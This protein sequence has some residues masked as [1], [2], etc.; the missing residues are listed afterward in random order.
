MSL[1]AAPLA[2]ETDQP[3]TP[4]SGAPRSSIL[5]RRKDDDERTLPL[6]T[7][8]EEVPQQ[9]IAMLVMARDSL[10][11]LVG[12]VFEC[13]VEIVA[14]ILRLIQGVAGRE[15]AEQVDA[16][17][18]GGLGAVLA[19]PAGPL[20]SAPPPSALEPAP[21]EAEP[22]GA[23]SRARAP[24]SDGVDARLRDGIEAIFSAHAQSDEE[25]A[26][27]SP[28]LVEMATIGAQFLLS[29]E[30]QYPGAIDAL[31]GYGAAGLGAGEAAAP[32]GGSAPAEEAPA[33][34][35]GVLL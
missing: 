27:I 5:P 14:S 35:R 12:A 1:T 10:F 16:W 23:P 24:V 13:A 4:A 9:T 2:S 28:S 20:Q 8:D 6:P 33:E 34:Q 22:A 30:R 18:A 29:V 7:D 31:Q 15:V 25:R 3:R 17:A 32:G 21:V 19:G 26:A 11:R